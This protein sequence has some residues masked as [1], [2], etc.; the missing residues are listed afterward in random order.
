MKLKNDPAY[1]ILGGFGSII[2][3]G[4]ILLSLPVMRAGNTEYSIIS[5]L[6]TSISAVCVTGLTV[7]DIGQYYSIYGQIVILGLIQIGGLGYMTVATIIFLLVGKRL[8]IR[9]KLAAQSRIGQFSMHN[10]VSFILYIIKATIIIE[11]LGA[12]ILSFAW[13]D[14]LGNQSFYYGLFHSV[15]AF[16]NAGFT[17]FPD[18]LASFGSNNIVILCLAMLIISGGIGF[19][20]IKDIF[21]SDKKFTFHTKIV[22]KVTAILII[23]PTI[24]FFIFEY[25]NPD[26]IGSMS[27]LQKFVVSFFH[28]VTSRTAGFNIVNMRLCDSANLFMIIM[29]MFIGASPAGTG[30]GVKTTTIAVLIASIKSL[31]KG[32]DD[33][34][35]GNKRI[36]HAVVQKTWIIIYFSLVLIALIVFLMLF[37]EKRIFLNVFFEVVSAF[38]TVGLSTG[39]TSSLS[40]A[41]KVLIMITMFVGRLGPLTIGTALYFRQGIVRIRYPEDKILIG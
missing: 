13:Y 14:T 7:V 5:A 1:I 9:D 2:L 38:G 16:C 35:I 10:L 41:N 27:L 37:F 15:S 32:N 18:N 8:S 11:L 12:L 25:S 19:I 24:L 30:G 29:L 17:L 39:I 40:V 4:F 20:V 34:V 33:A 26:T 23:I 3:L 22:L 36:D 21:G 31:L 6:F 28:S